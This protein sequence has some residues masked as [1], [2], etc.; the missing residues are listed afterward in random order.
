MKSD[1]FTFNIFQAEVFALKN[2]KIIFFFKKIFL[3]YI[4]QNYIKTQQ[5]SNKK[6]TFLNSFKT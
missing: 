2:I 4:H 5:K 3:I 6:L 1:P